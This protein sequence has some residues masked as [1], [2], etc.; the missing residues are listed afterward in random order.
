LKEALT[1]FEEAMTLRLKRQAPQDQIEST[2]L[3]V[4]RTKSLL[5]QE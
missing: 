2:L 5:D 1:F 4:E 3:A